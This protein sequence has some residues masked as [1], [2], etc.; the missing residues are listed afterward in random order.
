MPASRATRHPLDQISLGKIVQIR[1]RLL[2]AQAAGKTVY[3]LESGDPSFGLAPHVIDALR[4]AAEAGKTHYVPNN[5]IPELRRALA[6]KVMAK[7]GFT[8]VSADDV[9]VTNG[10]MN[11][12]FVTF[13]ALLAAGDEV[14]VPD[15][16]WTEVMENIRLGGGIPVG[17]PLEAARDFQYDPAAIEAAISP[18]TVAIFVNT[19][20]NP[21]GAVLSAE[22]LRAI[23][24]IARRHHLWIVADEAYEDVIYPPYVHHSA[25]ALAPDLADR[26]VSIFSFS[27]SYAMSGLRTGFVVTRAESL[28]DR[29]PKILR[30]T[31]NGVNS[32]AQWAALAAV[33]GSQEQLDAM[34]AEYV[35]RRD[36]MIDALSGIDGVRPFTPR[37]SFFVWAE[38]DPEVYSR[39]GVADA[40]E[41]S[42][43]LAADG[44]GSAPG[45]A[46][47]TTCADALR[48][49][50]S[51]DTRMVRAGC[52]ALR[53]ALTSPAVSPLRAA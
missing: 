5:G 9:F 53:A 28:R 31:I 13:Q 48:F 33:S 17:V 20:H 35:V 4:R 52:D 25:A 6:E 16:M 3:R 41:L 10:A 15:P 11:A 44:I 37:G 49:S 32:L 26:I 8:D 2:A 47:G 36:I 29:L 18:R 45:S 12:L 27:K 51:C 39:L 46:F 34:R 24:A 21:T 14:I 40:D 38:L 19:P 50:F 30:C 7:N 1:E 42:D 43:R 22:T 23:V